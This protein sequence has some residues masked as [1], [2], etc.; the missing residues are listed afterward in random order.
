MAENSFEISARRVSGGGGGEPDS[1]LWQAPRA[2]RTQGSAERRRRTK[3]DP[4]FME[5]PGEE[6]SGERG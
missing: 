6:S 4:S 5:S 3:E 1:A 2:T